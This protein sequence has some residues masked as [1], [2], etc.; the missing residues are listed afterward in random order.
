[1]TATGT[2]VLLV[3]VCGVIEGFAQIALKISALASRRRIIWIAAGVA[4]FLV[5]AVAY[6]A[7][8]RYLNVNVAYAVDAL[9]FVAVAVLSKWLLDEHVTPIR[10]LGI[11]LICAGIGLIVAEA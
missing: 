10:W 11:A 6:S 7:A 4:L 9:S 8:L 1:M 3:C 2:G 5:R